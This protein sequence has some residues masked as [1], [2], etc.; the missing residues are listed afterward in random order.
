MAVHRAVLIRACSGLCFHEGAPIARVYHMQMQ[1]PRTEQDRV[2]LLAQLRSSFFLPPLIEHKYAIQQ[3]IGEGSYGVVCSALDRESGE[4]VA[5]K[6]IIG[7]LEET[8]EATRTLRELKFLR[9]LS[10]HENIITIKDVLLPSERDRFN[11]VFVVL[12]L[13][14]TDLARVLRSSIVLSN[15]HIRWL[16]YQLLRGMAFLHS[17][18]VF[19]RDLKPSNIL[20]N[21]SCDLRIIDFG[22]ARLPS[23]QVDAPLLT[24]Y[25][26]TRWYRA[27]E[28]IALGASQYTTA[29]DMWSVGCI[30]GEMLNGGS[31]IFPGMN[32]QNQIERI[33]TVCR[34]PASESMAAAMSTSPDLAPL[35]AAANAR[36]GPDSLPVPLR[37]M[38]PNADPQAVDLLA[39]IL[40][41]DPERRISAANAMAH[42]Y[43][44]SL[45]EP[46]A[47][48]TR[49]PI[50]L[51]EFSFESQN[52]SRDQLRVLFMEEILRYHPEHRQSYFA[53]SQQPAR[54]YTLQG[55]AAH[56]RR[57][58]DAVRSSGPSPRLYESM[59]PNTMNTFVSGA[60]G[61][62]A[63]LTSSTITA[64]ASR[65]AGTSSTVAG[66]RTTCAESEPPNSDG[67]SSLQPPERT[68]SIQ[69]EGNGLSPAQ[70]SEP[71]DSHQ[72]KYHGKASAESASS[73]MGMKMMSDGID[74]MDMD[75]E[76]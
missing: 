23:T 71:D 73:T 30:F 63:G 15:D 47:I 1:R 35:F 7:V 50:P 9:L 25:V 11:D 38:L 43:F 64:S 48:V 59:P 10:D 69:A 46:E 66:S 40:E 31:P 21:A 53:E 55:Q 2:R 45:H 75:M 62:F 56:V 65:T 27:P 57:Q 36:R 22:L 24:D 34:G 51:E 8:P 6:R 18:H 26:A 67:A 29:I 32:N 4:L 28:L 70:R 74:F 14:P 37:E 3:V 42:P 39:R 52:L 54:S 44:S 76:K 33:L 58:F 19:H 13:M 16:V 72:M 60:T 17:A 20:I 5:V 12:E 49:D 41:L 61:S 68:N